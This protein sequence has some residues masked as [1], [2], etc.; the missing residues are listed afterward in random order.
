[1]GPRFPRSIAIC[2]IR[3]GERYFVARGHDSMRNLTFYRPLGGT[4]EFGETGEQ[5]VARELMEE[6]G[7]QVTGLA[8]LGTLENL[9]TFE[10]EPGHEIVL[11]YEGRFA[12]PAMLCVAE[13]ECHEESAPFTAVWMHAGDFHPVSAPLFPEGL[14]DLLARSARQ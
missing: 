6:T 14:Q 8:Y 13:F 10:G 11:V 2:V 5:T 12:D 7:Q 4:I 1:M 3:D 9:Y